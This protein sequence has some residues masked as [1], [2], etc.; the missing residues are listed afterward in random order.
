MVSATIASAINTNN[1]IQNNMNTNTDTN[2]NGLTSQVTRLVGLLLICLPPPQGTPPPLH[3]QQPARPTAHTASTAA[4][5]CYPQGRRQYPCR[6]AGSTQS[7]HTN[8]PDRQMVSATNV[9][10][11]RGSVALSAPIPRACRARITRG[12]SI[13]SSRCTCQHRVEQVLKLALPP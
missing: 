6:R 3:T 12:R 2:P 8:V 1:R 5:P 10:N 4:T 13:P 9:S 11:P 7:V